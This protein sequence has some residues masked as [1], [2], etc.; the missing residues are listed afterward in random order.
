MSVGRTFQ[1]SSPTRRLERATRGM[2]P[3]LALFE[4]HAECAPQMAP[5]RRSH[6]RRQRGERGRSLCTAEDLRHGPRDLHR[7]AGPCSDDLLSAPHRRRGRRPRRFRDC[8]HHPA[9][10]TAGPATKSTQL[11]RRRQ[12]RPRRT[13]RPECS[14]ADA[15]LGRASPRLPSALVEHGARRRRMSRVYVVPRHA[16]A[17]NE[18]AEAQRRSLGRR[19]GRGGVRLLLWPV[20]LL[21]AVVEGR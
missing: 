9:C 13:P 7:T 11:P 12:R 18:P 1:E 21:C 16:G 4:P 8:V 10:D 15:S 19:G 3:T 5:G 20:A 17:D 14:D 6:H 2:C